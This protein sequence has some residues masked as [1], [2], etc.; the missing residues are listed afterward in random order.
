MKKKLFILII[1]IIT[2]AALWFNFKAEKTDPN[3]LTLYGN[4]DIRQFDTAFQVGGQVT[5]MYFEEGDTVKEGSLIAEI[6]AADYELQEAQSRS[7]TAQAHAAMLQALSVYEKYTA[8]Y[9]SGAISKL[10]FETAENNYNEANSN[11][12]AA[13]AAEQL[14]GRQN[15][16]S[17]LYAM[18]DGVVTARLVEPGTVVQKGTAVYTFSKPS[19][20]WVRTY[21][22]E[23][24]LGNIYEGMPAQI[25]TDAVDQ[26]TGE[27][28]TYAGHI[29]YISPVSEF[30]P[31]TVETT[32][33]R[34]DLVY[35]LRVY[36]DTPDKFLCQGMPATVIINLSGTQGN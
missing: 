9:K 31:K 11:Y 10:E 8:L 34:T 13:I 4:V 22:T 35:M 36:A 6:D 21:V 24:H 26:Q 33:L 14:A 30:T 7:Q 17:R 23:V 5:K 16:Y 3:K 29:G 32:D 25:I 20:I 1:L 12:N 19:P 15:D 2:G 27:R 18:Q 28:K